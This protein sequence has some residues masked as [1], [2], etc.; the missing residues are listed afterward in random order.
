VTEPRF[1]V[2]RLDALDRV[3][4]EFETTPVRLPLGIRAFGVNAYGSQ[5]AGGTVIEDHDELGP[6]AGRHEELYV[7]LSGRARFTLDGEEADAP[8]GTLVFVRDPAVRRGA[9][10]EEPGTTVLVVGGTP[11]EAFEPSPWESWL[12][13]FPD[14]EAKEYAKAAEILAAALERHPDNANV[15]YNLACVESL[16]GRREEALTHLAR[17]VELDPRARDWARSDA[18]LDSIREDPAFPS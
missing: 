1:R 4:G 7:V 5:A 10:A 2:A 12:A 13:A 6:G 14:Y 18:D 8:A 16:G 11:G 3:P 9:V 15:L 17:A